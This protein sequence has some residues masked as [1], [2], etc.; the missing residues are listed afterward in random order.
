MATIDTRPDT[1]DI[2][3]YAGDTLTIRV[4]APSGVT[5][6]MDWAAQ[7][8]ANRETDDVDAEF[9]ITPPATSGGPAYLV[10]PSAVCK[11]LTATGVVAREMVDGRMA[12]VQRYTGE[13]DV[14][15]SAA[16]TDPVRTLAQGTLTI[17]LDVTRSQTP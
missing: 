6:G 17:E 7:V 5:D 4:E 8:K 9:V 14:Q 10:L 1:V 16:G 15:V 3:H 2:I 12:V 13:W 11:A